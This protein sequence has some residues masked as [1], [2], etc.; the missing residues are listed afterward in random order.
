MSGTNDSLLEIILKRLEKIEQRL[1]ALEKRSSLPV[2]TMNALGENRYVQP[3]S[4][5]N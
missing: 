3:K 2:N 5:S 1:E 4:N